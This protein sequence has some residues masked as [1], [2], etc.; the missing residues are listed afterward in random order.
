MGWSPSQP[1]HGL[2]PRWRKPDVKEQYRDIFKAY[3][4][5]AKDGKLKDVTIPVVGLKNLEEDERALRD[6][7]LCHVLLVVD[8]EAGYR[9]ILCKSAFITRFGEYVAKEYGLP[10]MGYKRLAEL[11]GLRK[12]SRKIGG[13]DVYNLY[14]M[15][16]DYWED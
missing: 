9:E 14:Y 16:L 8:K 10:K 4:K 1:Q 6:L 13:V 2:R 5:L 3:L 15:I 12:T 7:E 11:I